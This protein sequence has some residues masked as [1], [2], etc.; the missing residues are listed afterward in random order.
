MNNVEKKLLW[1]FNL[2]DLT[3]I[4][5]VVFSM[6][7]F[8][9]KVAVG[10]GD[11]DRV[12]EFTYICEEA[13]TELLKKVGEGGI[14]V[15]AETGAELGRVKGIN[16]EVFAATPSKARASIY[17]ETEGTVLD[18]GV[19]VGDTVYLKGQNLQLI[20]GDSVFEVYV[21]DIKTEK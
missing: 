18:H 4:A 20:V 12:C 21:A 1:K 15:D 14:C 10:N 16:T 11:G 6:A 2:L 3:L 19:E 7:A 9:Y 5:L 13:P 8:L 17:A